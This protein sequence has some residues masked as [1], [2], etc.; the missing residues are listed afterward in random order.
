ML[1]YVPLLQPHGPPGSSVHEILQARILEWVAIFPGDCISCIDRGILC[2]E[3][4]GKPS[5]Y[6]SIMGVVACQAL[7]WFITMMQEV[8]GMS[9]GKKIALQQ[10]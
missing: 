1:S 5:Q 7:H 8:G 4:P 6:K 2:I 3:P 9:E 10:T